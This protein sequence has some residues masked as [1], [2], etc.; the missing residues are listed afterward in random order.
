MVA[1]Y[2]EHDQKHFAEHPAPLARQSLFCKFPEILKKVPG[3]APA[4]KQIQTCLK[5]HTKSSGRSKTTCDASKCFTSIGIRLWPKF[6][7][8]T[9]QKL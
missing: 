9:E 4:V 3:K 6:A 8:R 7:V 1:D 2:S 5:G